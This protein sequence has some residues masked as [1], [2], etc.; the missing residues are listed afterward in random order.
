MVAG[1]QGKIPA[2]VEGGR[3][4]SIIRHLPN[5]RN[6][7]KGRYTLEIGYPWLTYG[8]IIALELHLK[9]H[10]KVLEL[11]CGGS[12]LFFSR[13][14]AEVLSLDVDENWIEKTKN[15]LPS[16]SN[17][18]FVHGRKRELLEYVKRLPDYYFNVALVDISSDCRFRL[19]MIQPTIDKLAEGG[20]VI[21]DNYDNRHLR[22]F[23]Y[24]GLD[25]YTFDDMHYAGKGTR[26][27]VK[28]P[29]EQG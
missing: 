15:A 2:S 17:V 5:R 13:R 21:I 22:P 27:C 25:V 29:A 8:T 24:E 23:N 10:F 6:F 4:R 3:V 20:I 18:E 26:I 7:S 14:C 11:G 12:T 16:P 9:P 28:L 1:Q 19:K